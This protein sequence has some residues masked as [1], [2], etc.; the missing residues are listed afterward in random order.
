MY[1]ERGRGVWGGGGVALTTF[2]IHVIFILRVIYYNTRNK[3]IL[4]VLQEMPNCSRATSDRKLSNEEF[5]HRVY[6]L[7]HN[8][9]ELPEEVVYVAL[10]RVQQ[11]REQHEQ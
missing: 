5:C 7:R 3:L 11:H 1:G 8:L 2:D 4:N 9:S 10:V 6:F